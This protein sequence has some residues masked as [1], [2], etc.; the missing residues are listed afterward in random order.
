MFFYRKNDIL[1]IYA[2][3]RKLLMVNSLVKYFL[4]LCILTSGS[5]VFAQSLNSVEIKSD[6][7][8]GKI[9][10]D[11]GHKSSVRKVKLSDN[12]IKIELKNTTV[13]DNVK[14]ICDNSQNCDSISVMQNG[15]NVYINIS[16]KNV[17]GYQLLYAND[18]S[19]IPVF[20]AVKK[21]GLSSLAFLLLI[22]LVCAVKNIYCFSIMRKEKLRKSAAEQVVRQ[23][24]IEA[25]QK[26][27]RELKTLRAKIKKSKSNAIHDNFLPKFAT[28][29]KNALP[30]ML[31]HNGLRFREFKKVANL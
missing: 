19:S 26:R 25:E 4:C 23:K 9:I 8:G 18:Y 10:L 6:I 22:T 21:F 1:T 3:G 31:E 15:N 16:A 20:S 30:K 14:T 28:N 11:T 2:I 7:S 13:A 17:N 12:E 29:P 5:G 24:K 27:I